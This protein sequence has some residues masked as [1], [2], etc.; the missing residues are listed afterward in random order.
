MDKYNEGFKNENDEF[1][2]TTSMVTMEEGPWFI[3]KG[4]VSVYLLWVV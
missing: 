3:L 4:V 2:R 1:G